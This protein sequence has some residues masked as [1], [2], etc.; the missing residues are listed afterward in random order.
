[1]SWH[2]E[3]EVDCADVIAYFEAVR[4]RRT[5]EERSHDSP[6]NL[7]AAG[8]SLAREYHCFRCHGEMG[9]GGFENPNSLKGYVPGYFGSDFRELTNDASPDSIRAWI[10]QGTDLALLEKPITGRIARYFFDRQAVSMPS[11]QSLDPAEIEILV[12][13]LIALN[14]LGPMTAAVARKYEIQSQLPD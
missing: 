9:Q 3:Y 8:E 2:P 4:L 5:L 13:Y 12:R 11:Y 6:D 14:E 1:M 10:S 7:L